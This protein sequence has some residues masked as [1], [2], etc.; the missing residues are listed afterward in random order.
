LSFLGDRSHLAARRNATCDVLAGFTKATA[1][2]TDRKH[3]PPPHLPRD[4]RPV[5]TFEADL[6]STSNV[7]NDKKKLDAYSRGAALGEVPHL[8]MSPIVNAA[9][10]CVL[11][12]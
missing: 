5:H 3:Y 7:K 1:P 2:S 9:G 11:S 12:T 4:F 8:S 10:L 6:S